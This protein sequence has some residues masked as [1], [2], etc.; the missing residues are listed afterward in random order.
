MSLG[1]SSRNPVLAL[2]TSVVR[3]RNRIASRIGIARSVLVAGRRAI[4]P[5]AIGLRTEIDGHVESEDEH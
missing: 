5:L 2:G 1:D 3:F 4:A